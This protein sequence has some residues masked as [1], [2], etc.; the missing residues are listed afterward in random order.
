MQDKIG[1]VSKQTILESRNSEAWP[2]SQMH[3]SPY[4]VLLCILLRVL[5]CL[6]QAGPADH[7]LGGSSP[8]MN[9]EEIHR[10]RTP[11]GRSGR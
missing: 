7:G 2:E 11:G 6:G 3:L 9:R 4:Y 1:G 5:Q 10:S 8:P